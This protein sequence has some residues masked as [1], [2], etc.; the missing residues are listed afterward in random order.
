MLECKWMGK[1]W[2]QLRIFWLK[3]VVAKLGLDIFL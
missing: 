2:L 3:L 1:A